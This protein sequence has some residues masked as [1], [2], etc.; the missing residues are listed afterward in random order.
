MRMVV[1]LG[2][3]MVVILGGYED[4]GEVC[5]EVGGKDGDKCV[6]EPTLTTYAKPYQP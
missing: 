1:M 3:R 6:N 5:G 2:V 4:V